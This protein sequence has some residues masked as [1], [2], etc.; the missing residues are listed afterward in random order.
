MNPLLII[1]PEIRLANGIIKDYGLDNYRIVTKLKDIIGISDC[2]YVLIFLGKLH[3]FKEFEAIWSYLQH[4]NM[5]ECTDFTPYKKT[6]ILN[7][8][9]YLNY[10]CK[11]EIKVKVFSTDTNEERHQK[12]MKAINS[13]ITYDVL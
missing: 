4:H 2:E 11:S 9:C 5:T 13:I 6:E 10:K 12:I 7:V 3:L 1:A 8:T